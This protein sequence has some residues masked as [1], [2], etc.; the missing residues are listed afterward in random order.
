MTAH[1][2]H[3][4]AA[5]STVYATRESMLLLSRAPLLIAATILAAW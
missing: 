3:L 1:S 4:H 5:L 2:A